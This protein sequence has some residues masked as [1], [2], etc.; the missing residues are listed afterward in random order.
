MGIR[1]HEQ[2][3]GLSSKWVFFIWHKG[4]CPGI[5]NYLCSYTKKRAFCEQVKNLTMQMQIQTC[6]SKTATIV[7]IYQFPYANFAG[8]LLLGSLTIPVCHIFKNKW[9]NRKRNDNIEK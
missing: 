3:I 1:H 5:I 4:L 6:G 7:Y 8:F 2:D 9:V